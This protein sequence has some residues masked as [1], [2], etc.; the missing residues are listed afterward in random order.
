MRQ[1]RS[2]FTLFELLVVLAII[3]VLIGLLLAAVQKVREAASRLACANNLKQIGLALQAHHDAHG[4]FPPAV[5]MPYANPETEQQNTALNPFGPNWAVFLLPYLEQQALYRQANPA[6]YPGTNDISNPAAYNLSWRSIRG[7]RVKAYLCPSDSG[8]DVPFTDPSGAP[9]EGGW[10]RGNY[11]ASDAAGDADHHIGGNH[12]PGEDPFEG[13][14]KGPVMAINFGAKIADV[15]DG[16]SVTFLVHEV[17]VGV[18]A[19]DR[20]GT[21]ALGF[22][23]ASMVNGGQGKNVSPNNRE[24]EADEIEGCSKFWYPGIGTRDG[25]GC[26]NQPKAGSEGAVARSRHPGGVNACFVD[27][28]VQ[29]IKNSIGHLTWVL[30]QSRTTAWSPTTTIE[31]V[32]SDQPAISPSLPGGRFLPGVIPWV[33]IMDLERSD[34]VDLDDGLALRPGKVAHA[35]GH[36]GKRAGG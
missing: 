6:S 32:R 29:F 27:G 18:S 7:A 1:R 28:H 12:N 10:A 30:L 17:R 23:G 22:P 19:A 3:A 36:P 16:T 25:M 35:L 21:W 13:I 20:R 33:Y 15:T 9:A 8:H 31:P 4:R 24:D 11:A 26:I 34:A 2:G 14:N 5:L